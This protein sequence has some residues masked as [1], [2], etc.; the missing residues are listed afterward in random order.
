MEG[1][2]TRVIELD[3]YER[4]ILELLIHAE[5]YETIQAE[6]SA[7]SFILN[8]CLRS[9][10][11]QKLVHILEWEA[12]NSAWKARSIYDADKLK[13]YRFQLSASGINFRTQI[14]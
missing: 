5:S 14:S 12:H 3:Q 13:E 8:D 6:F 1:K 4:E 11:R 10:V 2:K 9:L 7:T